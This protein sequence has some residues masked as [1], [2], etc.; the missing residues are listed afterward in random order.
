VENEACAKV[1]EQE[2]FKAAE[3][4]PWGGC[5]RRVAAAIRARREGK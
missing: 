3:Q 4:N 2:I 1:A 5:R